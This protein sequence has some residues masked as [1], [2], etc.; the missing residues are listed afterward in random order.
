[1]TQDNNKGIRLEIATNNNLQ[2]ERLLIP[3]NYFNDLIGK[4]I[5]KRL[6]K[7]NS[8]AGNMNHLRASVIV[9]WLKQH[10]IRKV[11]YLAGHKFISSTEKDKQNYFESLQD[12]VNEFHPLS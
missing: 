11:Q 12:A 4:S 3:Q 6:K 1:M 8:K 9:N 5:I 10:N 7:I 2:N